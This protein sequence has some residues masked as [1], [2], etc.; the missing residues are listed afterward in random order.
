MQNQKKQNNSKLRLL[1][2]GN[3]VCAFS[4]LIPISSYA[5][6]NASRK[7]AIE[8]LR[9]KSANQIEEILRID[10]NREFI[11]TSTEASPAM[12]PFFV[13]EPAKI[14]SHND[15][16]EQHWEIMNNPSPMLTAPMPMLPSV[17]FHKANFLFHEKQGNFP[18]DIDNFNS[19]TPAQISWKLR[20]SLTADKLRNPAVSAQQNSDL[21]KTT[22]GLIGIRYKWGGNTIDEGFDCSGMVKHIYE[23]ALG[24]DLPRTARDQARSKQM[25]KISNK[26]LKPGDLVF[27]N[28]LKR[29]FSH[30]GV[31]MGGGKF[32]HAP[33]KRSYVRVDTMNSSYW[34]SRFNGARR[35]IVQ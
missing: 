6:T 12:D 24:L 32:V 17:D 27:F 21:M 5:D 10:P 1:I 13:E 3:I 35:P 31:Y 9:D 29:P 11:G 30:V 14:I 33:N 2:A 34:K 19:Q 4:L 22:L 16:I 28:T 8:F 7:A 26:E 15:D 20:K 25:K 23:K 18:V